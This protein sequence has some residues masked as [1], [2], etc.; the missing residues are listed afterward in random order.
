LLAAQVHHDEPAAEGLLRKETGVIG[1]RGG[2]FL[3]L[4]SALGDR[5]IESQELLRCHMD[6]QVE[7][8]RKQGLQHDAELLL[9]GALGYLG[10]QIEALFIERYRAGNLEVSDAI[11]PGDEI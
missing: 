9:G 11:S 2:S 5:Q 6:L 8:L 4:G 3:E 1:G 10:H 7:A